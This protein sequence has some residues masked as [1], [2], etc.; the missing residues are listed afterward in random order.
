[1]Y[2]L[3]YPAADGGMRSCGCVL[4][5]GVPVTGLEPFLIAGIAYALKRAAS[6]GGGGKWGKEREEH[7]AARDRADALI[8]AFDRRSR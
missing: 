8:D 1:M 6:P 7:K 5:G 2:E 3:L 4:R